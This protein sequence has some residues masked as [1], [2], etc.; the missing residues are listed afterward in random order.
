M[1]LLALI[2]RSPVLLETIAF[3]SHFFFGPCCWCVRLVDWSIFDWSKHYYDPPIPEGDALA[4]VTTK[5]LQPESPFVPSRKHDSCV[6]VC[7]Q[8]VYWILPGKQRERETAGW[9]PMVR[10]QAWRKTTDERTRKQD[11]LPGIPCSPRIMMGHVT[12]V[13]FAGLELSDSSGWLW[14]VRLGYRIAN[15]RETKWMQRPLRLSIFSSIGT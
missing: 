13:W 14:W 3:S 4:S 9:T 2:S 5:I 6:S 15:P 1:P 12:R 8:D 10:R 7:F 11:T